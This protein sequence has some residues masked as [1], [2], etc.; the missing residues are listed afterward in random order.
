MAYESGEFPK[1][2]IVMGGII[3]YMP[4]GEA[5]VA[6]T[7]NTSKV[8]I[9]EDVLLSDYRLR[10]ISPEERKRISDASDAISASK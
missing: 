9:G 3:R 4:F 10:P 2:K 5:A 1:F 7:S 8:E 6:Y